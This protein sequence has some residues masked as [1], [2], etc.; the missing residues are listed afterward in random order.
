MQPDTSLG[1]ELLQQ[2]QTC[3]A[4]ANADYISIYS[5]SGYTIVCLPFPGHACYKYDNNLSPLPVNPVHYTQYR[6]RFWSWK[7]S[8]CRFV[9]SN[10]WI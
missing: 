8:V 1:W 5:V 2:V 3:K 9:I 6:W 10:N 7:F 4:S